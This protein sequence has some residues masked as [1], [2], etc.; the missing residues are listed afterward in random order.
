VLKLISSKYQ[1]S[2]QFQAITFMK[3]S[4]NKSDQ[5]STRAL[6]ESIAFGLDRVF[7]AHFDHLEKH[8]RIVESHIAEKTATW[9][10]EIAAQLAQVREFER[11]GHDDLYDEDLDINLE[12]I[13]KL[14]WQAQFLV[15]YSTFEHV[16][17]NLCLIVQ[18][19]SE[20]ELSCS[21]LS[22]QG[23]VRSKNYLAKVGGVKAPF[24][25]DSW[26][27]TLLLNKLRNAI[28]HNNSRMALNEQERV[29]IER[30]PGIKLQQVLNLS[31]FDVAIESSLVRHAITIFSEVVRSIAKYKLY[32][33]AG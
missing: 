23:I 28:A 17:G 32:V 30:L 12:V 16:L 33:A 15:A 2:A 4:D 11:F 21:D 20:L 9:Q 3:T 26:A 19:R 14:Q 24:E 27:A 6:S 1:D 22:G 25:S 29:A 31:K 8:L 10:A 5:I 18:R 7:L 13:P